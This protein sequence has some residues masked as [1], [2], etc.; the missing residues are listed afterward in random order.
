MCYEM[1]G[2]QYRRQK[3]NFCIFTFQTELS[4]YLKLCNENE[5]LIENQ[6]TNEHLAVENSFDLPVE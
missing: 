2:L 3:K 4:R 5:R 6:S 1:S